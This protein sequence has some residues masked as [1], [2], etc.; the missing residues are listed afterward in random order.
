MC[1]GFLAR[2][3]MRNRAALRKPTPGGRFRAFGILCPRR[4][5]YHFLPSCSINHAP[6]AISNKPQTNGALCMISNIRSTL[7]I[8]DFLY[9]LGGG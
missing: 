8:S 9:I 6:N 1:P 5:L 4:L 7:Y 2:C 3:A